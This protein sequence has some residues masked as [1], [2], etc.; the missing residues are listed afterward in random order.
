MPA[1][2]WSRGRLS[3]DSVTIFN[4]HVALAGKLA[5][6][7]AA[8]DKT[9][10]GSQLTRR[11]IATMEDAISSRVGSRMPV[12]MGINANGG[13]D[14]TW[15]DIPILSSK[16]LDDLIRD[17]D[18][19]VEDGSDEI[20]CFPFSM[21]RVLADSS[22]LDDNTPNHS[23]TLDLEE[24]SNPSPD[25]ESSLESYS[26]PY[27]SYSP[28]ISIQDL[29]SVYSTTRGQV[30]ESEPSADL[31]ELSIPPSIRA[32]SRLNP[33]D[34]GLFN[35]YLTAVTPTLVPLHDARNPWLRYPA[36]ALHLSFQ[37]GRNHLLHALMA[38]AAFCLG[39]T[40]FQQDNMV[41]LGTK[42]YSLAMT[43]L[44]AYLREESPDYVGLLTTM[45][46]FVLL[47]VS[48][49]FTVPQNCNDLL[50]SPLAIARKFESL[51]I[52]STGGLG[53]SPASS[54]FQRVVTFSRCVVCDA[55][56]PLVED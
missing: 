1:P 31:L 12:S 45:L 18:I 13:T 41:A 40:G 20:S 23:S 28:A 46:T 34:A 53:L 44:R 37:E 22:W 4:H 3:I 2:R 48:C 8:I 14:L 43:E 10:C 19:D 26:E 38:H 55:K 36:I 49:Q 42:L 27:A 32:E 33:N 50:M 25:E 15:R 17:C 6:S 56:L 29:V 39:N 11:P 35:V 9:S 54:E 30:I 51:E 24:A 16:R 52:S 47:E 5:S 21:F 7:V